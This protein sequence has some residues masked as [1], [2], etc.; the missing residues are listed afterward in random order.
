MI[1]TA[2]QS[3]F[4][5]RGQITRALDLSDEPIS[6]I[7]GTVRGAFGGKSDLSIQVLLALAAWKLNQPVRAVWSRSESIRGHAKCHAMTINPRWG[8]TK[9]GIISAAE[10]E[11]QIDAGAYM[12]TSS[13]VL[14]CLHSICVGPYEIPHITLPDMAV[15]TNNIPGGVF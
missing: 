12:Y 8:A 6:V 5:D 9:D 15:F 13:S 11:I 2:G 3:V 4:D 10:V 7:Y 1:H 14:D